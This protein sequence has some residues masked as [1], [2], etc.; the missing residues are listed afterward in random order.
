VTNTNTSSQL[1]S[2]HGTQRVNKLMNMAYQKIM[3]TPT[4]QFYLKG[5]IQT[6]IS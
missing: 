2:V 1:D 4:D 5:Q 6:A 3:V